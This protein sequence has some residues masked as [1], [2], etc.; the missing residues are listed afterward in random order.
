MPRGLFLRF[1]RCQRTEHLASSSPVDASYQDP[2]ESVWQGLFYQGEEQFSVRVRERTADQPSRRSGR[3]PHL[4][5]LRGFAQLRQTRPASRLEHVRSIATSNNQTGVASSSRPPLSA[6]DSR[7]SIESRTVIV[8]AQLRG[9]GFWLPQVFAVVRELESR[10]GPVDTF[11][12]SKVRVFLYIVAH[13]STNL[14]SPAYSR[15]LEPIL[16]FFLSRSNPLSY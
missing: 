8:K 2:G 11:W 16:A 1:Q 6:F 15:Q 9:R 5:M 14:S 4:K 7:P 10:Y 13:T 3:S 12:P